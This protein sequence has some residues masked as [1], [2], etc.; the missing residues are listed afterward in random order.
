VPWWHRLGEQLNGR[1][2]RQQLGK[3]DEPQSGRGSGDW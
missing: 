1:S 2:A 3:S